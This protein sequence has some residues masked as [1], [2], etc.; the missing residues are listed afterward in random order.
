MTQ[1]SRSRSASRAGSGS[2]RRL[3]SSS[4]ALSSV[5][6]A[7]PEEL[8]ELEREV[9][10]EL[11]R[12]RKRKI[13]SFYPDSGPLRRELYPRHL[14]FFEL[15]ATCR[16]RLFIAANRVGKTNGVGAYETTLHLTGE[17]PAWWRGRRF[18]RE[19]LWWA[20]GDTG[21][22]TRDLVQKALAGEY[23]DLGTGMIPAERLAGSLPKSGVPEAFDK[24]YVR[25]V[26]GRLSTL[27]LKSYD[28][29]R[30]AFYGDAIDGAWLDEEPPYKIHTEV[31][32]RTMTTD[33]VVLETFTPLAGMTETVRYYLTPEQG[34]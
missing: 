13:D 10:R 6:L 17:Y 7:E 20:A 32:M 27:V 8:L 31:V 4:S 30:E 23:N 3:S 28:Q 26:S 15:G 14:E 5:K 25:H 33:G 19:V 22:T 29:G 9:E 1:A 16:E 2:S 11:E 18:E 24:L 21:K 12:R 34:G